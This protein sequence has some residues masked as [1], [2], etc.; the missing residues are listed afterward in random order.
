MKGLQGETEE[1]LEGIK[2]SI[3]TIENLFQSYRTHCSHSTPTLFPV[4]TGDSVCLAVLVH[5]SSAL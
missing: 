2:L 4:G 3:S 1:A 5:T